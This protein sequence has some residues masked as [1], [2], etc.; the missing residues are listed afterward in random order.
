MSGLAASAADQRR[1][2]GEE[3]TKIEEGLSPSLASVEIE[4]PD[5]PSLEA[6]KKPDKSDEL[7]LFTYFR[8]TE[9]AARVFYSGI[10]A[11]LLGKDD[12]L[13]SKLEAF[14]EQS[15]KRSDVAGDHLDLL[16]LH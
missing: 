16:A 5:G 11:Q 14:A 10:A 12:D 13:S 3:L 9:A 7:S 4:F 2:L 15:R 1:T 8:D 6:I